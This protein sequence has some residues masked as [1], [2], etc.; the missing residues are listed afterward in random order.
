M[1]SCFLNSVFVATLVLTIVVAGSAGRPINH[2]I[3]PE[4]CGPGECCLIGMSRYS[5][6]TC[7]RH[8][9]VGENCLMGATLQNKTLHYPNGKVIE[10][11]GVYRLFCPCEG[12]L[13]CFR[14]VCQPMLTEG[15]YRNAL[16]N[17][18]NFDYTALDDNKNNHD[19]FVEFSP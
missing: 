3:K 13:S 9:T 12:G 2:C 5:V 18:D 6:P 7:I 10:V 19:N 8:Q 17:I 1:F 11:F 4:D 14:A 15:I 16:Y